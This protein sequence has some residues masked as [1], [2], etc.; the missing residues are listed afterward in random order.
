MSGYEMVWLRNDQLPKILDEFDY[1][2]GQTGS[3]SS[4]TFFWGKP[5]LRFIGM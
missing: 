1:G 5:C 2:L 3:V 4:F